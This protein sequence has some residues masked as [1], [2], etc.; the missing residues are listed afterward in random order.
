[1]GRLSKLHGWNEG[2]LAA[3]AIDAAQH[4]GWER[5]SIRLARHAR[6]EV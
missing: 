4:K 5:S 3:V 2:E 1:M 6:E